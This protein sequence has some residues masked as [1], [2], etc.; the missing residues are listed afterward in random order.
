MGVDE[1]HPPDFEDKEKAANAPVSDIFKSIKLSI[2][3]SFHR[4]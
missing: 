1:A 4:F 3:L 2:P